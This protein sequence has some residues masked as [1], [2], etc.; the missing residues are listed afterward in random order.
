MLFPMCDIW[1]CLWSSVVNPSM[2]VLIEVSIRW[3]L[4]TYV[5]V[6]LQQQC[7]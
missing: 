6:L 4:S 3:A 1:G 2:I 5:N 7:G